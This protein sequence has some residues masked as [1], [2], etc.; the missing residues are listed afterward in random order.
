[1]QCQSC[2]IFVDSSSDSKRFV[3]LRVEQSPSY[4]G[5]ISVVRRVD[6]VLYR[7]NS[8]SSEEENEAA[9]LEQWFSCSQPTHAG[10]R[11]AREMTNPN[12]APNA[13]FREFYIPCACIFSMDAVIRIS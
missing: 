13:S 8:R 2:Q 5:E 7:S 1:V 10:I 4:C 12:F 3:F 9:K 6:I 11:T